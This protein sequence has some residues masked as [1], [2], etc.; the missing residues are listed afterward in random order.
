MQSLGDDTSGA[1]QDY[2]QVVVSVAESHINFQPY[3][4]I[5]L[6]WCMSSDL[7]EKHGREFLLLIKKLLHEWQ[8]ASRK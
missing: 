5:S 8:I 7:Q 4:I 1:Y 6:K 2:F 3:W